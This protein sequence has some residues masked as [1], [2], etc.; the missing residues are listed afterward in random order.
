LKKSSKITADRE[1]KQVESEDRAAL[2]TPGINELEIRY[3]FGMKVGLKITGHEK[4]G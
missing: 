2:K 3:K 1:F 4:P